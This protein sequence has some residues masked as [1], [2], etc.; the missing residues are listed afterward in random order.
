MGDDDGR[1]PA[2]KAFCCASDVEVVVVRHCTAHGEVYLEGRGEGGSSRE[3]EAYHR[4]PLLLPPPPHHI[5]QHHHHHHH[6]QLRLLLRSWPTPAL[7]PSS[8]LSLSADWFLWLLAR[9]AGARLAR[10][11]AQPREGSLLTIVDVVQ[12]VSCPSSLL[13]CSSR[14]SVS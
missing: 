1:Q 5:V 13:V 11:T 4:L 7:P 9:F 6:H 14:V 2:A 8:A 3:E 10:V 12:C